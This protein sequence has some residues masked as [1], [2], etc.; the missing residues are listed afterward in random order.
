MSYDLILSDP[1]H[2]YESL[3]VISVD[4]AINSRRE[5]FT[6]A[7]EKKDYMNAFNIYTPDCKYM[8]WGVER[9][10][11][12]DGKSAA[13]LQ[14]TTGYIYF[15]SIEMITP[16]NYFCCSSTVKSCEFLIKVILNIYRKSE[17]SP[18]NIN[19][20]NIYCLFHYVDW[21]GLVGLPCPQ[22]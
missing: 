15:M 12:R 19:K 14:L 8:T 10:E 17:I 21:F 20:L 7:L 3:C 2:C 9:I 4:I 18:Q 11:G 13:P 1:V 22:I 16:R 6:R 5:E